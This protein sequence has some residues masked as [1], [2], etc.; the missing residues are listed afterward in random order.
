MNIR[1]YMAPDMRTAFKLVREELGPDVVILSTR[2]IKGQIE[3]TVASDQSPAAPQNTNAVKSV[4]FPTVGREANVATQVTS[5]ERIMLGSERPEQISLSRPRAAVATTGSPATPIVPSASIATPSSSP[6]SVTSRPTA[7]PTS[8]ASAIAVDGELKALRRL[9][10]T[11]LAALAWNDLSRRTPAVAELLRE[12][13]ELGYSRE[14]ATEVTGTIPAETDLTSARQIVT[15]A[16]ESRINVT[17]D[18]WAEQGGT[19]AVVGQ[20]GAGKTT[21]LAALAARWVMRNGTQGTALIS[22]GE[23]RFGVRENLSRVGRLVGIPVYVLENINELPALLRRIGERRMVLVDT[24]GC[25]PRNPNFESHL[26]SL[27]ANLPDAQFA[28]AL[29]AATQAGT[30]REVINGYRSLGNLACMI[31]RTD[32]CTTLGG[33][34]SA[35]IESGMPV[36]YTLDGQRLLDDL[37]PAR[38]ESLVELASAL[39]RQH[40]AVADEELLARRLEGRNNVA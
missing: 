4:S 16:L 12:F 6:A 3:I 11:Q 38:A 18:R 20:S 1:R 8:T 31:T 36:A 23:S 19:I 28:L 5:A 37:R 39:A 7:E 15:R 29:S 9:L 10:E 33:L 34:L 25:S 26:E 14:I 2:R 17:G 40:G 35:I 21:A 13:T 30:V 24:A 27:R 22:A 32:E